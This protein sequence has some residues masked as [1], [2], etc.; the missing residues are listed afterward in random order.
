MIITGLY[1][2][3]AALYAASTLLYLLHLSRGSR[4][5]AESWASTTLN[6]AVVI[7]VAF[8]LTNFFSA[9][10]SMRVNTQQMLSVL[11]LLIAIGYLI[12]MRRHR[13]PI[14]GAFITP[15][16][17]LIYLGTGLGRNASSVPMIVHSVMYPIHVGSNVLSLVAFTLAFA[18]SVGYLTQERLL[19]LKLVGGLFQRLPALD[20]LD[21]LGFRLVTIGFPL[22]TL[23]V[24][25]GFIWSMRLGLTGMSTMQGFSVVAWLFFGGVLLSR[26]VAGWRGRR[27]AI[28]TILGFLCATATLLGYLFRALGKG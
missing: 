24:I 18:V 11:S 14:L 19:R 3:G 9:P 15:V 5:L 6:A 1:L 21:R 23:G 7:H 28:G 2:G 13:L 10:E 4:Q 25:T 12:S 22:F 26:V 16:V 8:L 27:A 17:F 20:V